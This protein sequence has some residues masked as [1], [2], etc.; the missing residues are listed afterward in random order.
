MKKLI[1]FSYEDTEIRAVEI[2][3]EPW[4]VAKDICDYFGVS[5]RNRLLQQ[6]DS[7]DKGGTRLDTPGGTQEFTVINESGFYTVI[8]ALN[9][10]N[11]RG[12]SEEEKKDRYERVHKFRRWVTH[13]VLP[14]IRKHGG[15]LTPEATEKALADPDFIIQLATNLKAERARVA[16]L[17]AHVTELEPKAEGYDSLLS[18]EGTFSLGDVAKI[19][20]IGRQTLFNRLRAEKVLISGGDMRNTPYQQY[21]KHFKVRAKTFTTDDGRSHITFKTYAKP[22]ALPF[23]QRKLSLPPVQM[24]IPMGVSA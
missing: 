15:Y 3:G 20:G 1:P 24:P 12:I 7:L 17:T 13:E 11:A 18:S 16:S 8:F 10:N 2:D 9:P 5:N 4:L 23:I 14:A 6:V 19:L 21:A 22:S